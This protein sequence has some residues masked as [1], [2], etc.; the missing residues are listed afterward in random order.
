MCKCPEC[1]AIQRSEKIA[2]SY[3][4]FIALVKKGDKNALDDVLDQSQEVL[5]L[6]LFLLLEG[7]F[8]E[9]KSM[10]ELMRESAANSYAHNMNQ[11]EEQEE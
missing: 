6:V 3:D 5:K 11:Q 8:E 9:A 2:E 7:R 10:A 1:V 4:E